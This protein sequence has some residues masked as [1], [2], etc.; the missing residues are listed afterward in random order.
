MKALAIR[1]GLWNASANVVAALAGVIGSI[2]IVRS[3]TLEAY[4]MFSY[5]LWLAGILGAIGTLALP[6]SLTKITSELRGR[7]QLDEARALSQSVALSLF[8]LNLLITIGT[9]IWAI[10]S[11]PAQQ[12]YLFIIAVI[13][14]P[15]ALVA[16]FRSTLW[17]TERYGPVSMASTGSS[18]LRLALVGIAYLAQWDAPGFVAAVLGTSIVEGIM[19]GWIINRTANSVGVSFAFH[20]PNEDTVRRYLAFVVPA[21]LSLPLAVIVWERSEIFFLERFSSIE[22]VGFYGLG[23]TIFDM[24]LALGWALINGFYPAISKDYGAGDWPQI[25]AKVHQA[26]RLATLYAVPLSFGAWA[27][28]DR[29]IELLYGPKM[30]AAVP[31]AQILSAG[32]LPGVITG[33]LGATLIAVGR[34]W[35]SAGLGVAISTV[36]I[37]LNLIL[38]PRF[39][40]VGGALANTGVQLLYTVVLFI[41]VYRLYEIRVSLRSVAKIAVIG[42]L[43]TFVLP[44]VVQVWLPGVWGLACAVILAGFV[45]MASAWRLGYI[46]PLMGVETRR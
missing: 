12:T 28:L 10:S 1:N 42:A 27:T 39:G 9:V 18:L 22:Q 16:V 14:I 26:L 36:N 3:L 31:V 25:R 8:G 4:G 17:G 45:Y 38:I 13:L 41:A 20:L 46:Q 11:P 29:L 6:N 37:A 30:D 35:F 40:A 15:T 5:Y 2:L 32:L 24:F 33:V 34:I 23:F 43:T 7:Y 44:G 19:L 21:T